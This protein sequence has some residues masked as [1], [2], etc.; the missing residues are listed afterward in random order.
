MRQ[1]IDH[2]GGSFVLASSI[3]KFI[4]QP[5]ADDP[6]TPMERLPQ[7]LMMNGLDGLY[8]QTLARSQHL[9][10]FHNIIS[11]IALLKEPLSIANIA[12]LLGIETFQ[13]LHVLLNMQAIIHVPGTDNK[14]VVTLC[15]TSLRDFLTT[16]LRSGSFFV[17]H[18]FHLHLSYYC[19]SRLFEGG[20]DKL[21]Y[22]CLRHYYVHWRASNYPDEIERFK[23]HQSLFVGRLPSHAFLCNVW[24]YCILFGGGKLKDAVY[25]DMLAECAR[26]MA[27]AVEYPD[28]CIRQ[29]LETKPGDTVVSMFPMPVSEGMLMRGS[30][31]IEHV[32]EAVQR[33]SLAIRAKV[34]FSF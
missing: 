31:N 7:T 24:W 15:H 8:S 12:K 1:L 20:E 16:E 13:V 32:Y 21:T 19:F 4:V 29:W 34:R 6:L 25:M 22:Y 26:H 23:A 3:F 18:S 5:T 28:S 17:P 2:V 33:A 30:T 9:P 10:H 11:T 14:G 27:M